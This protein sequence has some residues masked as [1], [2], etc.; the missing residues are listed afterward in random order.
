MAISKS[1]FGRMMQPQVAS[2]VYLDTIAYLSNQHQIIPLYTTSKFKYCI[3]CDQM[4]AQN[5][6]FILDYQ[7]SIQKTQKNVAKKPRKS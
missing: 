4:R 5:E 6:N 2:K 3:E 1:E 7:L